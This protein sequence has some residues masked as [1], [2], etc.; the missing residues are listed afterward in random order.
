MNETDANKDRATARKLIFSMLSKVSGVDGKIEGQEVG[1]ALDLLN[2]ADED[3]DA[4]IEA[5]SKAR[6]SRRSLFDYAAEFVALG[7]SPLQREDAYEL[8]WRTA[9]ADGVLK[10][11][12][13]YLLRDACAKL[14]LPPTDFNKYYVKYRMTF[15]DEEKNEPS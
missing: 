11:P 7:T 2:Y 10:A 4:C 15:V 12:E 13:K 3:R 8:L 14:Q 5:F 6:R 9:I 1:L